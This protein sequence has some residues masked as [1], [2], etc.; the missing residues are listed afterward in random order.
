MSQRHPTGVTYITE[1]SDHVSLSSNRTGEM[2]EFLEIQTPAGKRFEYP[3]NGRIELFVQTH[4]QFSGDGSDP[5]TLSL[6]NKVADSPALAGD[7]GSDGEDTS[8]PG[9]GQADVVVYVD[10]SRV[11]PDAVR[12]DSHGSNPNEVDVDTSSNNGDDVDVYYLFGDSGQI[13]GRWYRS[14]E[15]RYNE[16]LGSTPGEVHTAKT[17]SK[18]ERITFNQTFTAAA[19]ERLKFLINTDVDLENW[20]ALNNDGPNSTSAYSSFSIPVRVSDAGGA[21]GR[22]RGRGRSLRGRR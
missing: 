7:G 6:S 9:S 14:H 19:K 3:G 20:N 16:V 2:S 13:Q 10:G 17:F 12:Y 11:T 1:N 4:E 15:E 21:G 22:G 5:Q 8:P 18:E